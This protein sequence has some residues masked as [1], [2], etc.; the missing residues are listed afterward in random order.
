[1]NLQ[2]Y[3]LVQNLSNLINNSQLPI[4]IVYYIIKDIYQQ[5]QELY[6]QQ[7]TNEYNAQQEHHSEEA[8][9]GFV[10]KSIEENNEED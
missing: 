6:N 3:E 4:G 8:I 9:K 10:E 5:M 1:M 2:I 7:V